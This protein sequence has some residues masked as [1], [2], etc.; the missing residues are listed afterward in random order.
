MNDYRHDE[1]DEFVNVSLSIFFHPSRM[2]KM[3]PSKMAWNSKSVKL[4]LYS[5]PKTIT[6]QAYNKKKEAQ[7]MRPES[8]ARAQTAKAGGRLDSAKPGLGKK[9]SLDRKPE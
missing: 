5:S 9:E 6:I 4:L 2:M 8:A 1:D 7:V 3:S